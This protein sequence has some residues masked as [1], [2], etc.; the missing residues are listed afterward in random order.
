LLTR[1]HQVFEIL[2]WIVGRRGPVHT[3]LHNQQAML[4]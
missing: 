1:V 3:N 4:P 2:S